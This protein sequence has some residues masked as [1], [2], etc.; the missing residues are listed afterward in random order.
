MGNLASTTEGKAIRDFYQ[1][2]GYYLAR[3]VFSHEEVAQ[4]EAAFDIIV[5]Q[6][7]ASGE[8]VNAFWD[9][10]F[11]KEMENTN[12]TV[13]HTHSVHHFSSVWSQALFHERFLDITE[14]LIGPNII[15]HHTKLFQKPPENGAP[16]PM[17]QDWDYFP[18]VKDTMMAGIIH[19]SEATEEMGCVR[20]A[21][22]THK[23]GRIPNSHGR[24]HLPFHDEYPLEKAKACVAEPGDVFFFSYFTLHG[25]GLNT[26]K[27]TRKTVLV[28]MHAGD[29]RVEEGNKHSN[30]GI[31][32]RGRKLWATRS[33]H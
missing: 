17:H 10:E 28:Q 7:L 27:R 21:P 20:V 15:L 11:R 13:L 12:K 19:V 1:E 18:T 16:F 24:V 4:L 2:N 3:G 5:Q 29:D 32:L 14:C 33:N 6:I 9:G 22:G 25:S 30:D 31:V 8:N 26:S 23:L